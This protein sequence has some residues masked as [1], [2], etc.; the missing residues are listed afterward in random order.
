MSGASSGF[1][2]P[3]SRRWT[4]V[5]MRLSTRFAATYSDVTT[6]AVGKLIYTEFR[7]PLPTAVRPGARM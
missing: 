1:C 5:A 3:T 4:R 6:I 2:S 7:N